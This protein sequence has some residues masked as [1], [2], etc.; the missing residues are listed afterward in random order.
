VLP[1][2]VLVSLNHGIKSK[3][4]NILVVMNAVR[5]TKIEARIFFGKMW[6]RV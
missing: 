2:V 6:R 1:P 3:G 4:V 5:K